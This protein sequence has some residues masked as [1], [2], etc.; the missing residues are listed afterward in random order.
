MSGFNLGQLRSITLNLPPL[1]EQR[2]IAHV[3]GTLDD[4]IEL[5]R[6]MN[7][8]LEGMARAL[9]ESWFVDFDPVR[10][11][12]TL[13][14]HDTNHSPL[15]GESARG[16]SPQSSRWGEIKRSYTQQTLEKAKTYAKTTPTQKNCCG[17]TCATNNWTV[18]SSGVNNR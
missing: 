6:R 18:T 17:T 14:H 13:K 8:T 2:T 12:A 3:L 4:K 9:F 11:K 1:P 7:E 5:N 15:E 10:A 16:R